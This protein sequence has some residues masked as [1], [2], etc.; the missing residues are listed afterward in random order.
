MIDIAALQK[1]T[2]DIADVV[3]GICDAH[4]IPYY[5]AEGSLLGAIRHGGFIP[6]D[7]DIDLAI[8]RKAYNQLLPILRQELPAGY[9]LVEYPTCQDHPRFFAQIE[10]MDTPVCED[11]FVKPFMRHMW[12]DLFPI[13][14]MPANPLRRKLHLW[15][16]L[17][18][19]VRAQMANADEGINTKGHHAR[20]R[21][22]MIRLGNVWANI[23]RAD[24]KKCFAQMEKAA[25]KYDWEKTGWSISLGSLY[26][27]RTVFPTA[28]YNAQQR[29]IPFEGRS[30]RIPANAE[31]MLA[32]LYGDYMTPPPED[33]R[34]GHNLVILEKEER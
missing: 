22:I 28:F 3:I 32:S 29:R 9:R 1:V 23:T 27:G 34:T 14:G 17:A 15:R 21:R 13:D 12:I 19:R 2:L 4:N 33:K 18:L 5:V 30:W 25:S 20:L 24:A 31:D 10:R 8:P 16:L 7:E 6:W 11:A 26:K